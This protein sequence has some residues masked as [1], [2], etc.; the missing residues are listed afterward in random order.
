MKRILAIST[1]VLAL[2]LPALAHEGHH[3][4]KVAPVTLTGE[5]LDMN[6]FMMHPASGTGPD[7]IKCAQMCMAKG[8][9]VGFKASDGT[10][11]LLLGSE[12]QSPNAKV[13]AFAGKKS[14][15]TGTV[16]DHDGIKAIE[17]T[18]IVDAK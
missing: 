2:A 10:V 3:D 18:S 12:H 6:C 9:A 17:M 16:V 1:A 5:V 13:S 8:M 7:H 14:T 4:A 15:I 11:Y